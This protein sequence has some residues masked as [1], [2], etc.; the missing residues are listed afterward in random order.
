M[1]LQGGKN[2]GNDR[3]NKVLDDLLSYTFE[4][5]RS[6]SPEKYGVWKARIERD[7]EKT[8]GSDSI[9]L[10]QIKGTLQLNFLTTSGQSEEQRR[11]YFSNLY[12]RRFN[13]IEQLISQFKLDQ[14]NHGRK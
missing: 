10:K 6:N 8:Y 7:I 9:E 5:R 3:C 12:E 14:V 11:I 2:S 4:T 13:R 1:N